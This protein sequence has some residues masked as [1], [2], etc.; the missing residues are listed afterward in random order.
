MVSYVVGE[1]LEW[2]DVFGVENVRG[3]N[4]V[5]LMG[6]NSGGKMSLFELII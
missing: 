3:E 5:I 1:K 2:F 4:V 6:V